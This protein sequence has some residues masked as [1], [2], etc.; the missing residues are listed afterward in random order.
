MPK[1]KEVYHIDD[2][3]FIIA[4]DSKLMS[5]REDGNYRPTY[6]CIRDLKTDLMW[7]IPMSSK[8]FKFKTIHD[9]KVRK[10]G[11]CDNIVLGKYDGK[12]AAFLIQNTFPIIEKYVNHLHTRNGNPV[13]VPNYLANEV[14]TK[15][16]KIMQL[17]KNGSKVIFTDIQRLE[18]LMIAE[19]KSDREK[20]I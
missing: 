9:D 8:Y 4:N 15:F 3:Y 10:F 11:S 1:E 14:N 18:A 16:N 7:M 5:N 19:L 6:F 17:H 20:L 13:P 12:D 2:S